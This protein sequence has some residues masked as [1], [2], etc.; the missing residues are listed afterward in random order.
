[1][2]DKTILVFYVDV[3][4]ILPKDVHNHIENINKCLKFSDE[5]EKEIIKYFVPIRNS[6]TRIE[7]LN[8]PNIIISNQIEMNTVL[9]KAERINKI[10]TAFNNN[11]EK[12]NVIFE[13]K[14]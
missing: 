12:R 13:K 5:D 4:N 14:I 7:C 9:F 11:V 1:M 2:L 8:Y 3:K 6:E 10:M